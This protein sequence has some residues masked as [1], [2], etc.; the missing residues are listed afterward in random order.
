MKPADCHVIFSKWNRWVLLDI[1][2]RF[3][4]LEQGVTRLFTGDSLFSLL[5][6]YLA[7]IYLYFLC[8]L[9][10]Q[11]ECSVTASLP[12]VDYIMNMNFRMSHHVWCLI[13][14]VSFYVPHVFNGQVNYKRKPTKK[15]E[16]YYY[17]DVNILETLYFD[18]ECIANNFHWILNRT[19]H[20]LPCCF[21]VWKWSTAVFHLPSLTSYW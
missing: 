15:L 11:H 4:F 21:K 8:N 6:L 10:F 3:R 14:S 20:H 17:V 1:N 9:K 19:V 16:P 2:I 5:H 13:W 18:Q 12:V 7:Y